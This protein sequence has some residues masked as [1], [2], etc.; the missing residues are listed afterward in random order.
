MAAKRDGSL[1]QSSAP[2]TIGPG[3]DDYFIGFGGENSGEEGHTVCTG[4]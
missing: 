4:C 2:T 1:P 3:Q